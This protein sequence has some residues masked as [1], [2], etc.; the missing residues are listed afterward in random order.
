MTEKIVWTIGGSDSGAGAGIQA[1]IKTMNSLGV[2]GCSV[3][4]AIT[5]QNSS[6]VALVEPVSKEMLEAQ[7]DVLMRD[8][9]PLA[10]KTGMLY[11]PETVK[12]VT[13]KLK[14]RN[15]LLIVD[16]VMISSSGNSLSVG[17][18]VDAFRET[19]LPHADLFTPNLP[20]A[21]ALLPKKQQ[22][23][24][25]LTQTETDAYIEDLARALTL[26][27]ARAV[28]LKGGHLSG[29]YCQD[30]FTDGI[31]GCWLTSARIN[32]TSTH[33]TGCTLSAA[34]AAYYARGYSLLDST[35][36]A[37]AYVNKGL[38]NAP[39]L[40]SGS[41]PLAHMSC[42]GNCADFPWL[43][44][45]AGAGRSR[46]RFQHDHSL[47]FYPI[48]NRVSW[49]KR[50]LLAGATTAQLRI[51]D[52]AGA[53]L[54]D[55]IRQ[56]VTL[57]REYGCRLYINDYWQ[58]SIK[59]G[60]YGVHLGQEDL[61]KACV[62]DILTAGLRLGISTH[63]PSEV[64]RVLALRPSYIAIGPIHATTTKQ[65]K[66]V[67]QGVDGFKFWRKTLDYPLVAIGGIF[68]SNA[69]ELIS[70]GADG[71]AVVR[72]ISESGDPSRRVAQWLELFTQSIA[73]N[74]CC[75]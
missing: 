73:R 13:A 7:I 56:G 5:A 38:R 59:Y 50:L 69:A 15:S 29:D 68:L 31:S 35:V 23:I 6:E 72:D 12:T 1:D 21:L 74:R 61:G 27:G 4:T 14:G 51:K 46:P 62:P 41:G 36:M 48:V 43:T 25:S 58:Q 34:I 52:L 53:E 17:E 47:Q 32:T 42:P 39:Y 16:P 22:D 70:A 2:Y 3:I 20:E 30:F 40:G 11:A 71:I 28:L 65:M 19:L 55:E 8:L 49:L 63:C 75:D 66:F 44:E 9:P 18:M 67:P 33:G 37:K 45:T 64:A 57:A 26:M 54:E 60:A 10:V 24:S